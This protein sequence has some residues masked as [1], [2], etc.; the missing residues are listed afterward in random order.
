MH[1]HRK[2]DQRQQRRRQWRGCLSQRKRGG[3]IA[4]STIS[5]NSAAR[6]GGIFRDG[7]SFFNAETLRLTDSTVV[8]NIASRSGGGIHSR[9]S[10]TTL[11]HTIVSGNS[12]PTG[13]EVYRD[14]AVEFH[15]N[16]DTGVYDGF[17]GDVAVNDFNLFGQGGNAGADGLPLGLGATDVVPMQRLASILGPLAANGGPTMTHA[18]VADSPALDVVPTSDCAAT[19]QRGVAR[20]QG[21]ACDIGAFERAPSPPGFAFN[22]FFAPVSNQALNAVKAGQAIPVRFSLGGDKGLTIFE[23]GYPATLQVACD[24]SSGTSTVTETT[25]AGNSSL[26]YDA[27]TDTY[28]FVW[29]TDKAWSNSCRRLMLRFTDGSTADAEFR[30]TK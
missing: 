8:N 6:G 30:F 19:D 16:Y 7:R 2:H 20:P 3:S 15:Y 5:G 1:N 11:A 24:L 4:N 13:R 25:N 29:K 14:P 17:T 12:A 23:G 27:L 28:T 26:A 22:G 18:L 21:L 10:L 9:L